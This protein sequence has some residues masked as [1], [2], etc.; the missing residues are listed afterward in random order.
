MPAANG[1]RS[2]SQWA[3][4]C[5]IFGAMQPVSAQRIENAIRIVARL[6]ETSG[7]EYWPI[8]ERLEAELAALASR[9][10]RLAR[11]LAGGRPQSARR[12]LPKP[13]L[14]MLREDRAPHV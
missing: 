8:L 13:A 2:D 7:D 10:E 5:A 1:L 4:V 12:L 3:A 11:Y 6:I 9:E 14:S